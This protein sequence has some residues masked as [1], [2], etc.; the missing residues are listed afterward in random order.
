MHGMIREPQM[1]IVFMDVLSQ[2]HGTYYKAPRTSPRSEDSN[3]LLTLYL[4]AM[5]NDFNWS[6]QSYKFC[7]EFL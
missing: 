6:F 4:A 3:T 2:L 7:Y 5:T 1:Y